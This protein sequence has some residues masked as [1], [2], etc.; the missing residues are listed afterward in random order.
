MDYDNPWFYNNIPVT[1]S[2]IKSY[3]GFVYLITDL[4][5]QK[6]YVGKKFIWSYRKVK[7]K[8]R[9]QK[10]ESDWKKYYSS[11][12]TVK[13]IGKTCPDLLRRE[14]LHLCTSAGECNFRE[15]DEIIKR[16]A[17][18]RDDY[19]NDNLL[20]EVFQKE[21]YK[22]FQQRGCRMIKTIIVLTLLLLSPYIFADNL[23]FG[24]YYVHNEHIEEVKDHVNLVH[25]QTANPNTN[26]D[27]LIQ[28]HPTAAFVVEFGAYHSYHKNGQKIYVTTPEY[29]NGILD[30]IEDM[31]AKYKKNIYAFIIF[32]EAETNP[33]TQET[34]KFIISEIKKR[35]T[36]ADIKLWGNYDN[37]YPA[38]TKTSFELVEGLDIVSLTPSYGSL[39]GFRLCSGEYARYQFFLDAVQTY[40]RDQPARPISLIIISDGWG[41][42]LLTNSYADKADVLFSTIRD[43]SISKNIPVVGQIV[44]AYS[45]P[46]DGVVRNNWV[47]SDKFASIGRQM[48][49]DKPIL[50]P[51]SQWAPPIIKPQDTCYE[52]Y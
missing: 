24:Y 10:F 42:N 23:K 44:F 22:V 9:R 45:F 34:L 14:I 2:M 11:N 7:G 41:R 35:P 18:W 21:C 52:S 1:F 50:T 17:L 27:Y 49:S 29:V 43:L 48:I 16:D 5:N 37:V 47:V 38:Y 6:H 4:S 32:D 19:M 31:V 26:I 20:R 30:A 13:A 12:D 8:T 33:P 46:G 25:I 28:A 15:L 40:N 51:P 39:C 36:L 3:F